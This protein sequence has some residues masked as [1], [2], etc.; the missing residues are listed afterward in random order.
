MRR[1]EERREERER[2]DMTVISE[3]IFLG[4]LIPAYLYYLHIGGTVRSISSLGTAYCK[5]GGTVRGHSQGAQ[6]G[7]LPLSGSGPCRS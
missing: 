2:S 5:I 4:G 3:M 7:V 1:E 6:L